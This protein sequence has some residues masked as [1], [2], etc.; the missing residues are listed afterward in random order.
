[1]RVV[2]ISPLIDFN[3]TYFTQLTNNSL[4]QHFNKEKT[5]RKFL[6]FSKIMM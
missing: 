5:G 1:M 3:W 6:H 4:I 2:G